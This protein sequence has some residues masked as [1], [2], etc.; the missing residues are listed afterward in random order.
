[1]RCVGGRVLAIKKGKIKNKE[2]IKEKNVHS[3]C[4]LTL[5]HTSSALLQNSIRDS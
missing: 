4:G 2:K 3:H 1:M 5:E